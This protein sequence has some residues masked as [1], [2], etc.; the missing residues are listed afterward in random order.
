MANPTA[1]PYGRSAREKVAG[2]FAPL[3]F[4]SHRAEM[5]V[6]TLLAVYAYD[7][8]APHSR[9]PPLGWSSWVALGHEDKHPVLDYCDDASVHIA[10]EAFHDVGLY[11]AGYRHFHLDDCWAGFE[12][13]AE[14]RLHPDPAR[15]PGGMRPIIDHA[16]KRGLTFGLYTCAGNKT[17]F[18]GRVGSRGHWAE[19]A[20]SFAEWG[21]DAVKMDW[22]H[23][24]GMDPKT[25]YAEMSA[26]LNQT[27]RPINL[28]MCEWGVDA[29]WA[30]GAKLAQSWRMGPDHVAT[31]ASTRDTVRASA[32]IPAWGSGRPFAWNDMDML[33]AG[34]YEQA[35]RANGRTPTMSAIEYRTEVSMWAISASPLVVTTPIMNCTARSDSGMPPTAEARPPQDNFTRGDFS[36]TPWISDLQRSLLLNPEVLRVNQDATPQGRPVSTEPT[37]LS[38]WAR[39]LST[40]EKAVALYNE[41]DAPKS[42]HVDFATLGW[43]GRAADVRD[44][45]AREDLGTF[46]GRYPHERGYVVL[47][48]HEAKLLRMRLVPDEVGARAAA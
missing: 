14:G 37:D 3:R 11:G 47:A 22:C 48:A 45:W 21:V 26:A 32:S 41:D 15:F 27:G 38:V 40:G 10:I 31:W 19:D 7:N 17:C 18:G 6:Q 34:N 1:R 33:Q 28:N 36:C 16:H 44:L 43:D 4:V 46:V 24:D 35:A 8:G 42:V 9:L 29:P 12:R 2:D 39:D 13:D 30:W 23:T 5:L 25:A 20:A